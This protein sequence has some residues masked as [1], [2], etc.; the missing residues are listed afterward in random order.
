MEKK[1]RKTEVNTQRKKLGKILT[2]VN[3]LS[4]HHAILWGIA[5]F[6]LLVCVVFDAVQCPYWTT[7]IE[8]W[9]T[10]D[11]Y[12]GNI[13]S[14]IVVIWTFTISLSIY[15]LERMGMRYYGIS[16][17]DILLSDVKLKGLFTLAGMILTELIALIIAAITELVITM[18]MVAVQQFFIMIYLFL[19][20]CVKTSYV[21]ILEQISVEIEQYDSRN[22]SE[23]MV[24]IREAEKSDKGAITK[25]LMLFKMVRSLDY[26]D[27]YSKDDLLKVLRKCSM[28]LSEM[29]E[30]AEKSENSQDKKKNLELLQQ[31]VIFFS[32][33]ITLDIICAAKVEEKFLDILY[34]WM[35]TKGLRLE[36][37][38]GIIAAVYEDLT[39]QSVSICQ[40]LI[41]AEHKYQRELQIWSAVYNVY[42][43]DFIGE[44][45]RTI[46]TK[47]LFEKLYTNRRQ[48]DMEMALKYWKYIYRTEGMYTPLFEYIF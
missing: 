28:R 2:I 20:V 41:D 29:V 1:G 45:W 18:A 44:E 40:Y 38:Q 25:K 42:M 23:L 19:L 46:Y 21:H 33:Q 5:L 14:V 11:D 43:Q 32:R 39:S 31:N 26:D 3:K 48:K 34:G 35:E 30:D 4:K 24:E 17:S 13:I 47:Q 36:I 9:F 22:L 6:L 8:D 7:W 15:S 16:M 10:R 12:M 27:V 37:K